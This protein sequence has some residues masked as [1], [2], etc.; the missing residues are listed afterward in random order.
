MQAEDRVHRIGQSAGVEVSYFLCEGT[1]D[2]VLWPM[3][4]KKMRV[5]GEVVE[6]QATDEFV[7]S[8]TVSEAATPLDRVFLSDIEGFFVRKVYERAN[9]SSCCTELVMEIVQEEDIAMKKVKS[10][11]F[12]DYDDGP[13]ADPFLCSSGHSESTLSIS[14]HSD[15]VGRVH[16]QS[17][18]AHQEPTEL[19]WLDDFI[20]MDPIASVFVNSS[21]G[22]IDS[23]D[24]LSFSPS[25]GRPRRPM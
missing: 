4:H 15:S 5:L 11:D 20:E 6:G 8:A 18:H 22:Q 3:L 12:D 7:S 17:E 25:F 13:A 9:F 2:D 19:D 21:A 16:C 1:V 14:A 10:D 24:E 23:A